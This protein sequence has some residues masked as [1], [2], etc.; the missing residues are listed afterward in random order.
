MDNQDHIDAH[1]IYGMTA[2]EA[3]STALVYLDKARSALI[4]APQQERAYAE[5]L[6]DEVDSFNE[7]LP[8][9]LWEANQDSGWHCEDCKYNDRCV[10][11]EPYGD[12]KVE[13]VTRECRASNPEQ[14][15]GVQ[16]ILGVTA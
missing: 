2:Q 1:S 6:R 7:S 10:D 11:L 8:D 14:C 3:L 13:R 12:S 9:D 5:Y 15:P 16:D 4:N